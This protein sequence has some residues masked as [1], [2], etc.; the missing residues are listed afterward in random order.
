CTPCREGAARLLAMLDGA[1]DVARVRELSEAIQLASLCGLGAGARVPAR[2]G[3]SCAYQ[4][5]GRRLPTGARAGELHA[6]ATVL[7]GVN[8]LGLPLPQLCKD[9][10]RPPLG[11]CRTCLV[12]GDG[13]RG[14][15]GA[16]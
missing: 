15:P 16:C 7:D 9:P 10:D 12:R 13:M 5:E 3:A 4:H 14:T 11:A 8:R 6:G 2:A 1:L